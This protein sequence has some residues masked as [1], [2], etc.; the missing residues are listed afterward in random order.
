[1]DEWKKQKSKAKEIWEQ[2][3]GAARDVVA[4]EPSSVRKDFESDPTSNR[5]GNYELL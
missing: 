2:K 4:R 1:M 3:F 5:N